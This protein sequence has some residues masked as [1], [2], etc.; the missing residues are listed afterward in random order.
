MLDVV[1]GQ[2]QK[3]TS[4]RNLLSNKMLSKKSLTLGL[5]LVVIA[6]ITLA[7]ATSN[8]TRSN[9]N[10]LQAQVQNDSVYR[11]SIVPDATYLGN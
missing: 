3:I 1:H 8:H 2:W 5:A 7:T 11:V 6:G 10:E 9:N 4:P